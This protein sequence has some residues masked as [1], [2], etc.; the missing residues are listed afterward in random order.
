MED[1][2]VLCRNAA[3]RFGSSVLEDHIYADHEI[4]GTIDQRP[5]YRRLLAAAKA[6]VF[7]AI[8]VESQ[9]RLWRD[10]AEMHSA[11][12]RLRF[13]G[14]KVFSVATGSDLTDKTGKLM[15]SVMGWKDEM[16]VEDL[17]DKTAGDCSAR[18]AGVSVSGDA[19][20]D[21][22]LSRHTTRLG[23][24]SGTVASS[25]RT[26]RRWFGAFINCTP[27]GWARRPSPVS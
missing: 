21:I 18:S 7:D 16:Y 9:D 27:T 25:T 23:R 11:L 8:L 22:G 19:H 6:R 4:S 24:S 20:T 13:F 5:A 10:Q 3:P 12:K 2:I 14:V 26:R 1:Q 15:A 17:M